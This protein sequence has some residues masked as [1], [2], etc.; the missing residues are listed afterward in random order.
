[1][2]D[3][4]ELFARRAGLPAD[5]TIAELCRRL[6]N[7]PL[8]IELA[9]ARA[10]V[11][12][13]AQLLGRLSKRLD[14][15]KGGRDSDR[16]QQTLRAALDWSYAL[17]S[18]DEQAV[19][20]RLAVFAGGFDLEAAEAVCA[21]EGIPAGAVLDLVDRLVDKSLVQ[22]DASQAQ[23]RYRLLEPIRQ[24]AQ[25]RLAE[26]GEA[27]AVFSPSVPCTDPGTSCTGR[28]QSRTRIVAAPAALTPAGVRQ[29]AEQGL[30]PLTVTASAMG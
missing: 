30:A 18:T 26:I 25:A 9:A 5:D 29:L 15:L 7:L 3:A 17:L 20:R 8:A 2:T 13:P 28:L 16:R 24:Y 19:F 22:V 12:S 21:D 11:L 23:A 4:V 6:D 14:L 1:M 27:G 10:A